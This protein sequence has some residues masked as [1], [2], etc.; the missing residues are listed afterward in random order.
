[1]TASPRIV[2]ATDDKFLPERVGLAV[3][4]VA[5]VVVVSPNAANLLQSLVETKP[6]LLLVDLNDRTSL[7][8]LIGLVRRAD[9]ALQTVA[10]G[11]AA[12]ADAVLHAVRAGAVD[13]LDQH[14][15]ADVLRAQILRR[16]RSGIEAHRASPGVFELVIA[17]QP[18]G[19]DSLF[20]INLAALR[21]KAGGEL[22]LIDCT[23]PSSEAAAAL[24]IRMPY[25]VADAAKDVARLDRTLATSALARHGETGMLVL[26]LATA[27]ARDVDGI[28]PDALARLVSTMRPL[29]RDTVMTAGGVRSPGLLLEFMQAATRIYLVCEQKFTAVADAQSMLQRIDPGADVLARVTLVVDEYSSAISLTDEQMRTTLGL[30]RSARLPS[31]RADLINSLNTGRPLVLEQPRS[32]Y[33]QV[34]ARLAELETRQ[35]DSGPTRLLAG[36]FSAAK[37][38]MGS[39]GAA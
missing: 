34:L 35:K 30:S 11:D 38:R 10:I 39:K 20:A 36:A 18:G 22:L 33:A 15:A 16:L 29:F 32:A 5:E 9:P 12:S 23:L 17:P 14:S 2:L 24:D 25:T 4:T 3:D 1:M 31:A 28:A 8:S 26:P 27:A 37:A 6:D 7:H 13:F 19:G 21:A